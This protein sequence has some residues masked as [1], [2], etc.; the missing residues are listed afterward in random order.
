[1][2]QAPGMSDP[3]KYRRTIRDY[4]KKGALPEPEPQRPRRSD[5][6]VS[7]PTSQPPR[8]ARSEFEA[9]KERIAARQAEQG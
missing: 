1:M 3:A 5:G 2:R 7:Q 4:I 9:M 8:S 6:S